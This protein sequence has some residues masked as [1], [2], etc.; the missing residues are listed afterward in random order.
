MNG[1]SLA[2]RGP[3]SLVFRSFSH[4]PG[5]GLPEVLAGLALFGRLLRTGVC[6]LFQLIGLALCFIGFCALFC[7][8]YSLPQRAERG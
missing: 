6:S 7:H 8:A 5:R 2:L 1:V 3:L 4:D